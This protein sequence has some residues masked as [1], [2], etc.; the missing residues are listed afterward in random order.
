MAQNKNISV[1][2]IFCYILAFIIFA[3]GAAVFAF[4]FLNR[5]VSSNNAEETLESFRFIRSV[6]NGADDA[7][8]V[9][10]G[11]PEQTPA[12]KQAASLSDEQRAKYDPKLLNELRNAMEDYNKK[13]FQSKQ[14]GLRDAWS[15]EEA[16]FD[17]TR[18]GIYDNVIAELRIPAMNCDLPLYLGAT[19]GNMAWGA[20]QLGQTSM[21]VGGADTNCVIAGHRGCTNGPYFLYI[22][23][24]Q[25]GDKVYIDNLWG[26]IT[27]KVSEIK[28]ISPTDIE[29]IKIQKNK[30]MVTLITCHPYPYNYQRY[31]VFCERTVNDPP[32]MY[33]DSENAEAS[34][35]TEAAEPET[36]SQNVSDTQTVTAQ[37]A[38]EGDSSAFIK[39]ESV[40]VYVVPCF[41]VL[42]ALILFPL[43]SRRFLRRKTKR[44]EKQ[45]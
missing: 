22:Q 44:R 13:I 1:K 7:P 6:Y 25:V 23:N 41:V 29:A 12:Q 38:V 5:A 14:S 20:V 33:Q 45:Q 16:M 36:A 42:L 8:I 18:Y 28:I 40:L 19:W 31:A 26:T 10:D 43:T 34:A 32:V 21:P 4:P 39:F 15:Y 27:Y 3:G 37:K 24:L 35:N 2:V 30:D 9:S 17:L 11:E